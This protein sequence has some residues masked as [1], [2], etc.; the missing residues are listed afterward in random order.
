MNSLTQWKL[1]RVVIFCLCSLF[2]LSACDNPGSSD[3]GSQDR[4]VGDTELPVEEGSVDSDEE[5]D[6]DPILLANQCFTIQSVLT[7]NVISRRWNTSDDDEYLIDESRQH[8]GESFFFK[9]TGLGRYM[10]YDTLQQVL[11]VE[12]TDDDFTIKPL[13]DFS[14]IAEWA[15][16][17][18]EDTVRFTSVSEQAV[19]S[20]SDKN[21]FA[22]VDPNI[23]TESISTATQFRLT[24][25]DQCAIFPEAE[26]NA[27]ITVEGDPVHPF[28]ANDSSAPVWGIADS[29]IHISAYEFI[30]GRVN[31]GAPF[32]RYGITHALN[33][34]MPIHGPFGSTA[35][36]ENFLSYNSVIRFHDTQGYPTF[37]DWPSHGSLTHH[38]TYYR[39]IERTYRGGV[40][41]LVNQLVA[42]EI[43]CEL[44]PYRDYSC[45]EMDSID[46][47]LQQMQDMQ[48][49]IDAQHGGAGK[50]WF[51]VVSSPEDA[52]SV[53]QEG[54]LAVLLGIE[55][56]ALFDCFDK[57]QG[58]GCTKESIDASIDKYV[59]SGVSGFFPIHEFNNAL[60]GAGLFGP[61][62]IFLNIGNKLT[63]GDYFAVEECPEGEYDHKQTSFYP[64]SDV[65]PFKEILRFFSP[66]MNPILPSYDQSL[67]SHC[68]TEG[69]TELGEYLIHR[70]MDEGIIIETDHMSAKM[71]NQ[72]ITMAEIRGYSGLISSH[73]GAGGRTTT[74]QLERIRD[75]GGLAFPLPRSA[76]A[77]KDEVIRLT[78]LMSAGPH[79]VGIG[80]GSDVNGL[81]HLPSPRNDNNINPVQYPFESFDGKVI[82]ER[83]KTGEREFDINID[84]VAHYGLYPDFLQDMRQLGMSEEQMQPVF[85]SAEAYLKM[86]ERAEAFSEA[87][88]Q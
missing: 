45:N 76:A 30:G 23:D 32:H 58:V 41:L 10:L 56:A 68:N 38:Q 87:Q 73:T 12:W 22:L 29:H 43:L 88:D 5:V 9:A 82:F 70:M 48:D 65:S 52:R 51:R 60:G 14:Q 26:L 16:E 72:V 64:E 81:A 3:G 71:R 50:G 47:Q 67:V 63:T 59:S 21:E 54:K 1:S 74:S 6:G 69:I 40:R 18:I 61:S 31:H 44:Y 24:S 78:E 75:L 83:Q 34:C 66:L 84:G 27:Q 57:P 80:F 53:I 13:K 86:W 20:L 2:I 8:H 79:P 39:W 33:S 49:Y 46:L 4:F 19:L 55:S 17:F 7:E 35:F 62:K 85:Q 15:V 25:S 42:N 28:A 37:R 77:F 36:L 11:G